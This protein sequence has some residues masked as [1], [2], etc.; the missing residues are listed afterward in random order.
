M[1]ALCSVPPDWDDVSAASKAKL[2]A[3]LGKEEG[4]VLLCFSD[5]AVVW[6]GRCG[7]LHLA[8]GDGSRWKMEQ[9]LNGES[10]APT[11]P[12]L[13]HGGCRY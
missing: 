8:L 11:W 3:G 7:F 6:E 13:L 2:F 9:L 1:V 12:V 10:C 5:C 4:A